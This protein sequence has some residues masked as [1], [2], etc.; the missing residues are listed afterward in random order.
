MLTAAASATDQPLPWRDMALSKAQRQAAWFAAHRP[1]RRLPQLLPD[2]SK[3]VAGELMVCADSI[4]GPL[5]R[6]CP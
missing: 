1:E 3:V 6:P 4:W 2:G 5:S